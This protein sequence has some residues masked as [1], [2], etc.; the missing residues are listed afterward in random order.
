MKV[1][2]RI[3]ERKRQSL[4]IRQGMIL[5]NGLQIKYMTN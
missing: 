2:I 1:A 3:P 5:K 4:Q